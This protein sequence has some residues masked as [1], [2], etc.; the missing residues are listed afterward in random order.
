MSCCYSLSTH[1]D[2]CMHKLR[3]NVMTAMK[4]AMVNAACFLVVV[5]LVM[6]SA[7][8]VAFASAD[9][10]SIINQIGGG[11]LEVDC[12][13]I[14]RSTLQKGESFEHDFTASVWRPT[15]Y[16][17]GFKW[18]TKVQR[19]TVWTDDDNTSPYVTHKPCQHCVW[20]VTEAGFTMNEL[21]KYPTSIVLVHTWL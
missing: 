16:G 14:G 9:S 20:G 3:T 2:L 5:V 18:G 4:G 8:M 15:R 12:G 19:F 6:E 21:G 17:C 13:R 7:A 11:Q 1:C 10:F